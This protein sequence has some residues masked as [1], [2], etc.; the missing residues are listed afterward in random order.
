VDSKEVSPFI[1]TGDYDL[2]PAYS[3]HR[4]FLKIEGCLFFT[5]PMI[6]KYHWP[7]EEL[8][9]DPDMCEEDQNLVVLR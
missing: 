7:S 2:F 9:L 4:W 6:T 1:C 5:G 8:N 3:L